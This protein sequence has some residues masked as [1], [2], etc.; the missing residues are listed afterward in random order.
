MKTR[1]F[2]KCLCML[3]VLILLAGLCGCAAAEGSVGI[4]YRITGGKNPMVILGSIHIGNAEMEPYGQHL[5]DEIDAADVLVF[6]CDNDAPGVLM[7]TLTMMTLKDGKLSDLLSPETN[8]L[9]DK[10]CK[11]IGLSA[12]LMEKFRPWAVYST[13][14]TMTAAEQMGSG[15]TT[16][17]VNYGVESVVMD[18]AGEKE[19]A[20]LETAIEQLEVMDGFSPALQEEIL[21]QSCLAI[22]EPQPDETLTLWPQ[23]WRE[24]NADAF[25]QDYLE[26]DEGLNDELF[27]EYH[28]ALVSNRNKTMADGLCQMLEDEKSHRYFVTVGLLH[29][30]LPEDSVLWELEQR[31]YQVERILPE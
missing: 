16:D 28:Q 17:A 3:T 27:T 14:T 7:Q 10:A 20:Y 11:E 8:E 26:D 15:S 6:E 9:L 19:Y 2:K 18:Y 31:G 25:A 22:L 12:K 5:L 1:I 13:L 24:G 4:C 29:L 30:V 21:R 23:W